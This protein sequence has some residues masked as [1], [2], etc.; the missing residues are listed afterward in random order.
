MEYKPRRV[1]Y[2]RAGR[3]R[4]PRKIRMADGSGQQLR[5]SQE[6]AVSPQHAAQ[7]STAT[8]DWR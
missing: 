6:V 8:F 4:V 7:P 5:N 1:G 3:V 2:A